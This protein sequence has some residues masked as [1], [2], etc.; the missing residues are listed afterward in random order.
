V[1]LPDGD[2]LE[3]L[4]SA[5]S[6]K[7]GGLVI[8]ITG[9]QDFEKATVAMRSGAY[10]YLAKPLDLEQLDVVMDRAFASCKVSREGA[11]LVIESDELQTG[12]I[13]G[14]SKAILEVHKQIGLASRCFANV[15]LRGESG[16]GKELV[17]QAIHRNSHSTGPFIPLNCSA[18]V[19]TLM[20]S[21]LFG[22][23]KGSFTGALASK[24]GQ[25]ELAK[26]GTVF[27]DEIGDLP[28]DLQIKL[29]RVLQEREFKR[30]G[31]VQAIPLKARV[32]TATHRDLEAMVLEKKFRDDLYYRLRVLEIHI[33]PLRE[34]ADDIPLLVKSLLYKINKE[35][36]RNVTQIP[37]ATMLQLF[38]YPW[39]GNVR[40]LE[41][42]LTSAVIRSPGDTLEL[43][44]PTIKLQ[45]EKTTSP[46]NWNQSLET[47]EKFHIQEVL[48][49][50]DGHFGKACE[51]LGISR[52]T[53]RKKILDYG[54]KASFN[55]E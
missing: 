27:L 44:M 28:L 52:P 11:L 29:L 53:L 3:L 16:V 19:S 7:L 33:P 4:L 42:L 38:A 25:L 2:G 55:E 51:I 35:V 6:E 13:I 32:I 14:K 45:V 39:P 1:L 48:N 46:W 23:E 54:L 15:L 26:N 21:E 5:V 12:K 10:D 31:G 22:H 18:I 17:A 20:E 9:I 47:V 8:L 50:T 41:N 30:V 36:H 40:E 37:E 24:V 49:H 34:R 43:T